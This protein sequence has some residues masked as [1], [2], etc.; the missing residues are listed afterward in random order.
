RPSRGDNALS[1]DS[2]GCG[3]I[4]GARMANSTD[5]IM[6]VKPAQFERLLAEVRACRICEAHLPNPP[7]P[8]LRASPTARVLIV[9]Q[10][11][12][13]PAQDKNPRRTR[14]RP[15]RIPARVF[16]GASPE[17]A[18][19][20]LDEAER[21]VRARSAAAVAAKVQGRPHGITSSQMKLIGSLASPYTRKVRIV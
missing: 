21:L 19:P 5:F 18:Q 17:P 7:R 12:G 3:G 6:R 9:G 13:R 8:V 1:G 16:P 15:R 10:A 11:P 20:A 4:N 2:G 14:A